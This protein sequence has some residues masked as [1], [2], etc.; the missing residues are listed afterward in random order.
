MKRFRL[1]EEFSY[2]VNI[3]HWIIEEKLWWGWKNVYAS[4]SYFRTEYK[5]ASTILN[6]LVQ[7]EE[8]KQENA[9]RYKTF[10]PK[11]L[12]PPLPDEEPME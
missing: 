9:K 12:Y 7:L 5:K 4:G 10:V 1:K 6:K 2:Y 8:R 11:V 3:T